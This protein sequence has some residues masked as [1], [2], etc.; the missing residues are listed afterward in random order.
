MPDADALLAG[1]DVA[2]LDAGALAAAA[3]LAAD[4]SE[5]VADSNG[6]AAYKHHLVEVLVGRAVRQAVIDAQRRGSAAA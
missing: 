1:L 5:P 4:A 3:R 2:D 6:S